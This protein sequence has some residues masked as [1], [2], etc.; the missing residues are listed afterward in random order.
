M[1]C[2]IKL[3]VKYFELNNL[4]WKVGMLI[5]VKK[6]GLINSVVLFY[7]KGYDEF[8]IRKIIYNRLFK[9]WNIFVIN[10]FFVLLNEREFFWYDK[11][12]LIL[13]FIM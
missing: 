4:K 5:I 9:L 11:L 3:F 7:L 2:V 6:I 1:F 13:M 10:R 12:Y 8:K